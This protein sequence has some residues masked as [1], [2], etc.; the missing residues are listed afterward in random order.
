[1]VKYPINLELETTKN[2]IIKAKNINNKITNT[3]VINVSVTMLETSS[4]NITI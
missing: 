2:K 1:M 4:L 3:V